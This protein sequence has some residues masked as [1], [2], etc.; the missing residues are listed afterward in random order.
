[1]IGRGKPR[2]LRPWSWIA[3]GGVTAALAATLLWGPPRPLLL[4][5]ASPSS[6]RGL[7]ALSAG[8]TPKIGDMV[9]AWPP[10]SARRT[11]AARSYLPFDVPLVKRVAAA[12]G[13]RVCAKREIISV[14]GLRIAIRR[15]RDPSGRAMPWWS[16]CVR[17]RHGELFLL[18]TGVPLA[19]DGRYFGVTR[20]PE[21]VGRARLL[22]AAA[23][24]RG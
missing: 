1:M 22:W 17:L 9:A 13:D 14:N 12:G 10:R 21:I 11:A 15:R 2:T 24:P 23:K 4:W 18:S 20:A 5:N 16:G 8:G 19:F 7:Y 6:P 3:S